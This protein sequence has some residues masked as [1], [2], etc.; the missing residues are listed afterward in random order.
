MK[1]GRLPRGLAV[2]AISAVTV[3]PL[4][5]S[6][7]SAA[8]AAP[9]AYA[10]YGSAEPFYWGTTPAVGELRVP[11]IWGKTNNLAVA[12]SSALDVRTMITLPSGRTSRF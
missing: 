6:A 8:P 12:D 7:A 2:A 5:A 10:V 4:A 3:V 1:L 9:T 11:F